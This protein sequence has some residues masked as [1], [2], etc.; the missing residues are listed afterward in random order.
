MLS[1]R[2]NKNDLVVENS[3]KKKK[4][5]V[6]TSLLVVLARISEPAALENDQDTIQHCIS[7]VPQ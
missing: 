3:K 2:A 6:T 1:K 5:M 4:S 7:M